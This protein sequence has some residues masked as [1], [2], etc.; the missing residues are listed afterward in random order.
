MSKSLAINLFICAF[1]Q[2]NSR[3]NGGSG[4]YP[5]FLITK[6]GVAMLSPDSP[7]YCYCTHA[8]SKIRAKK[9]SKSVN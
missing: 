3:L 5:S 2:L 6:T 4:K 1:T 9:E 7:S 8:L